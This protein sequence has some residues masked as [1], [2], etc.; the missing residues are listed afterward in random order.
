MKPWHQFWRIFVGYTCITGS[1]CIFLLFHSG[2]LVKGSVKVSAR[3][4][5]VYVILALLGEYLLD[6]LGKNLVFISPAQINT[7]YRCI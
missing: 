3:V 1:D 6:K 5:F 2:I 7:A 4:G